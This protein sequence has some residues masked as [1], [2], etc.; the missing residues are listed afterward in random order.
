MKLVSYGP[1]GAEQPGV[2]IGEDEPIL[3]LAPLWYELGQPPAD[4]NAVVGLLPWLRGVIDDA[5][6]QREA[7]WTPRAY[8]SAHR[9]RARRRSWSAGST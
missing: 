2:L 6:A 4:M 8:G 1:S 9:C 7:C 3:P 5:I